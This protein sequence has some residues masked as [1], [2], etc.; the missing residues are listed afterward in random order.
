MEEHP[1]DHQAAQP[2]TEHVKVAEENIEEEPNQPTQE[3]YMGDNPD[4]QNRPPQEIEEENNADEQNMPVKLR[5]KNNKQNWSKI[6]NYD[7][8]QKGEAY[9]G[10]RRSG[11]GKTAH[12]VPRE[13]KV[14]G[15]RCE[16]RACMRSKFRACPMISDDDRQSIF[17]GF[18]KTMTWDQ[19]RVYI[20]SLV[21]KADISRKKT[22]SENSR[23]TETLKYHLVVRNERLQV[24]QLT[25][26]NTLGIKKWSVRYWLNGE[27]KVTPNL[28]VSDKNIVPSSSI[29]QASKKGQ[30]RKREDIDF[31]RNFFKSLPR[32]PSHYCRSNSTKLY[33]EPTFESMTEL[34][35]LYGNECKDHGKNVLSRFTFDRIFD[36]ENLS[37]FQ[38]KKDVCDTCNSFKVNSGKVSREQYEEHIL[39]KGRARD[40]KNLDSEKAKAKE[41]HVFTQDTQSV[42]LAPCVNASAMYYKTKLCVHNFTMYNN[43]TKDAMTYWWDETQSDLSASSF[44]SC[45]VDNLRQTLNDDLKSVTLW[46]DGCCYQNRSSIMANALLHLAMEKQV[47]I[48]QKYLVKGHTMMECDSVHSTIDTI[49]NPKRGTKNKK[50][51]KEIYLPSQYAQY[52]R[53]ARKKPFPYRSVY[54]DFS[55]FHDFSKKETTIYDSIRP[56]KK[57][58]DPKVQDLRA[59]RYNPN[60]T[61][62]F[63]VSFDDEYA[64]LPVRQNKTMSVTFPRLHN[65]RL[66]IKKSKWD[67]LQEL[68]AHIPNDC[69]DYYDNIPFES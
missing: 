21:E 1:S 11:P 45:V 50:T 65:A 20:V 36:Q 69:H 8:R 35:G 47:V 13:A 38:P 42:K 3:N 30:S 19:R 4:L 41:I 62:E 55:F 26:L 25:F 48:E 27:G 16:S 61:I 32:L 58:G 18:W 66:K 15:P 17:N 40:E 29:T 52:A 49:L 54:L 39:Q 6:S 28:N 60:G 63:K 7:K 5:N 51:V 33:I 10:Y 37:L 31:L 14:I 2:P 43:G 67:H 57:S 9:V 68:K 12:D 23:R 56:G 34:Y 59:L 64:V 24:C 53:E 22:D 46:S 44:A